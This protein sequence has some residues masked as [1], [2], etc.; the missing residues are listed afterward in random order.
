MA[1]CGS[2]RRLLC[3]SL[4][5]VLV[6]YCPDLPARDP[7]NCLFCH[8][9]RRLRVYDDHGTLHNYYVDTGL[10]HQSIHRSVTCIGCHSDISKV[11]HGEVERVDCAKICH[12]DRFAVMTGENFSHSEVARNLR[13]SVHGVKPDDPP[14]V[15]QPSVSSPGIPV[16]SVAVVTAG[17]APRM[18]A[19]RRASSLAPVRV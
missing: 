8:K 19:T 12:L 17:V 3:L 15:A 14:E 9:Y 2:I 7:Q 13:E 6:G 4:F 1:G 11:P 16:A 10:F 18:S 5:A